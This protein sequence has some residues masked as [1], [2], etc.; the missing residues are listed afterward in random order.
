MATH[1]DKVNSTGQCKHGTSYL[2]CAFGCTEAIEMPRDRAGEYGFHG[3]ETKQDVLNDICDILVLP[4][5][6]VNR[7]SS[8]PSTVLMTAAREVGVAYESMPQACEA[9]VLQ[10]GLT[11]SS[12]YDSRATQSGGGSTVTLEGMQAL[13]DALRRLV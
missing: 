3:G 10:A 2:F 6:P 12:D 5:H 13:R 11:W 9:I 8:I 7:G 1:E 4:R